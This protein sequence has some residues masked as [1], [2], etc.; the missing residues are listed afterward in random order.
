[1]RR[2]APFAH[3]A[4]FAMC[5]ML[6]AGAAPAATVAEQAQAAAASLQAA[7]ASLGKANQARDRVQA[8]TKTITAYEEGLTA[9]RESLRQVSIREATLVLQFDAKRDRVAQLVGVLS[10]MEADPA[11]L[12]LLHP[13][14]PLGTVRSGM[15]IADVTPALQAEAEAMRA[16]LQ[17][18]RDLRALQVSAGQTLTEGLRV[19]QEARTELSKAISD[20]TNLPKRFTEDP[21]VLKGLLESADTLDA[22]ANGLALNEVEAEGMA[23]FGFAHGKLPLPVLGTVLRRPNEADGAGVR[24]PGMVL[25]TRAQALVTAPWSGTLR[26]RGPLLNFGNVIILEPGAGYLLVL[27]GMET[28]YGEVGEVVAAG[29]PLGLMGGGTPGME[30]FLVSAQDGGGARDTE[31]LYVELR[32]G[33]IATDPM[34]WF[35]ATAPLA[36]KQQVP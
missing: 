12:L 24:R 17:E 7:V 2:L 5:L 31:T 13:S 36:D 20:R 32:Q 15:M 8:L 34:P 23:D 11:P 25:A 3:L 9:L 33:S 14:G 22:F 30:E 29:A 4:P 18:V 1:M 28:V 35:T 16:E 21:E 27:A 19:A 26:Y 10:R 6:L